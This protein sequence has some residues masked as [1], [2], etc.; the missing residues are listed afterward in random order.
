MRYYTLAVL[1]VAGCLLGQTGRR[2][3]EPR[4]WELPQG[5]TVKE[6]GP[7]TYRFTCDYYYLD[8][9]GNLVRRERVSALYTRGLPNGEVRWA[10]VTVA[11]GKDWAD[12]FGA[13]QKRGF[14][15]GFTYRREATQEEMLS[16]EFFRGFPP[17]AMQE[18]NLVWDTAMLEGFGQGQFQNL[19]LNKPY[20]L[21]LSAAIPLAGAGTFQHRDIQLTWM[22]ISPRNGQECALIDYRAFFNRLNVSTPGLNLVG[23]SHYWGQIWVSLATKQIEYGTLYEAVMGELK[24]GGQETPQIVNVFRIGTFE[25]A[26]SR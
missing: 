16:P 21:D 13:P 15:E 19:A 25:R 12:T 24:L 10:D 26:A 17:M 5:L 3:P 9:K 18:R 22:G 4:R 11:E 7:Q 23:S 6:A 2:R 8:T 14:M 20:H 1:L